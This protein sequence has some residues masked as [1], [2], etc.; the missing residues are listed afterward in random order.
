MALAVRGLAK[1]SF[2][3][4]MATRA[5]PDDVMVVEGPSECRCGEGSDVAA[6][7]VWL[8]GM[9]KCNGFGSVLRSKVYL[10][11]YAAVELVN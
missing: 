2:T 11:R 3:V 9:A 10:G 5:T 4:K 1:R 8:T 7:D 6:E